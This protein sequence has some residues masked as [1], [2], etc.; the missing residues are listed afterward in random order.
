MSNTLEITNLT[1]DYGD[2]C[3]D[4]VS[5]SLPTG[6]IMGL[7]GP[8]GAGKTTIIKTIMNLIMKTSGEV[9]VFEKDHR[10][11]EVEIK[12]RIGFVYDTPSYLRIPLHLFMKTGTKLSLTIW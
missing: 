5:F 6:Y 12:K 2:F 9:K 11:Y 4:D 1:K 7:I 10:K 8:N 3:L